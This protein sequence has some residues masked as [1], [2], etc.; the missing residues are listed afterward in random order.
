[1]CKG[2]DAAKD[3]APP[4][5]WWAPDSSW[6]VAGFFQLRPGLLEEIMRKKPADFEGAKGFEMAYEE[7]GVWWGFGVVLRRVGKVTFTKSTRF[8]LTRKDGKRVES[9]AVVFYPDRWQTSVYDS[10][11]M[12]IVVTSTSVT[13]N[14]HNGYPSG[15]VK[16]AGG[17][18]ELKNVASFEVIGAIVDTTQRATK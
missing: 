8:V 15:N 16:F 12:A 3:V 4:H 18:V 2:S 6:A 17:S 5:V 10:R 9:E 7:G 13:C 14:P 1:M 11:K